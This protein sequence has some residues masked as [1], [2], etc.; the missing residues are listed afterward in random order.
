MR[1]QAQRFRAE[2]HDGYVEALNEN[3]DGFVANTGSTS[4]KART[5]LLG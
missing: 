1:Q 2:L 3:G 4:V 5:V